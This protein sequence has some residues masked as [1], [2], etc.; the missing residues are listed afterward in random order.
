[1]FKRFKYFFVQAYLD[2]MNILNGSYQFRPCAYCGKKYLFDIKKCNCGNAWCKNEAICVCDK[3]D[4]EI[5]N[6]L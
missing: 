5:E 3:C 2:M 4:K 1:M 6:S